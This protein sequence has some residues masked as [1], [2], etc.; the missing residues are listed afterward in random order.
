MKFYIKVT[1]MCHLENYSV[2]VLIF[3]KGLMHTCRF[4]TRGSRGSQFPSL[5][6]VVGTEYRKCTLL[7]RSNL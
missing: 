2:I 3:S 7:V 4:N 5:L 1:Q 6:V